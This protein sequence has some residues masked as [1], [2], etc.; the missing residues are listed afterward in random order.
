MPTLHRRVLGLAGCTTLRIH[1][2]TAA[3]WEVLGI[4]GGTTGGTTIQVHYDSDST[5]AFQ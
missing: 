2:R 3:I 1:L 5:T 4:A